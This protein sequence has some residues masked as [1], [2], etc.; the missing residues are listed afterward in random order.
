MALLMSYISYICQCGL[1][2]SSL[3]M[4]QGLA[5]CEGPF[6]GHVDAHKVCREPGCICTALMLT[7]PP[8]LGTSDWTVSCLREG[9]RAVTWQKTPE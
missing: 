5:Y 9:R 4:L 3:F 1:C 7:S 6:Q 8:L 2:A